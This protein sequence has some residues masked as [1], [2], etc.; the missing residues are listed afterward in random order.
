MA[1][2]KPDTPPA[3]DRL[4]V[5][6]VDG[7]PAETYDVSRSVYLYDASEVLGLTEGDVA[8]PIRLTFWLAW[9][10][11]GTPYLNG[12]GDTDAARAAAR[13][14]LTEDVHVIEELKPVPAGPPTRSRAASRTSRA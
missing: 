10:A 12:G 1:S 9:I 2:K 14:W 13:R 8:N 5:T 7:R 6:Y 3:G 4:R 11:A